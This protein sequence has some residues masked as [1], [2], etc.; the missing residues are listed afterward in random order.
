MLGLRGDKICYVGSRSTLGSDTEFQKC[1]STCQDFGIRWT[2][3]VLLNHLISLHIV[4]VSLPENIMGGKHVSGS[5]IWVKPAWWKGGRADGT[6]CRCGE[7]QTTDSSDLMFLVAFRSHI[8]QLLWYV[9]SRCVHC[10]LWGPF[11]RVRQTPAK[12]D[13]TCLAR[14][15]AVDMSPVPAWLMRTGT[16]AGGKTRTRECE[17]WHYLFGPPHVRTLQVCDKLQVQPD[18]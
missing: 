15:S 9:M 13:V 6:I 2:P 17:R 16:K 5:Y 3:F 8:H 11:C 12:E 18:I 10:Y 7:K 14:D 4:L 1:P